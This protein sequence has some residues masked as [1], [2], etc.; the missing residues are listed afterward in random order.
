MVCSPLGSL[1]GGAVC[2]FEENEL[3]G[4]DGDK[5]VLMYC[6]RLHEG[7]ACEWAFHIYEQV[8]PHAVQSPMRPRHHFSG[9]LTMAFLAKPAT[10]LL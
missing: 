10:V 8:R 6:G 7:L 5:P 9:T 3:V 4:G 2:R 1:T